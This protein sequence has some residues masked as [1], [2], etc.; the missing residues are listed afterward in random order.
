MKKRVISILLAMTMTMGLLVGCGSNKSS[1]STQ[2]TTGTTKDGAVIAKFSAVF[3]ATGTQAD[4][5]NKLGEFIK[6]E[7]TDGIEMEFYPSSQL[8]DKTA[9]MEGMISGT[10]EM[11]EFSATD[12]SN[13]DDM[14]SVFSLPYLWDSGLQAVNTLSDPE[15]MK[16]LEANAEQYG[17]MIIAWQN[18]GSR[19]IMNSKHTVKTPADLKGLTV[20]CMQ[21]PVLTGTI[22]A[23]GA[24]ATPLAWGEVYTAIQQ[25]T[26]DGCENSTPVLLANGL[27]E[28][29][30][31][32][33][34]TEQFIIPDPVVISKKWYDSLS[35]ENQKAIISAGE[36]Y[37]E[38][39]N[40]ELWPDAEATALE[41][42]KDAGVEVTEVDKKPFIEATQ[43]IV[44]DYLS[45]ATQEQ[46][47]LYE[48]LIE[49]KDKYAEQ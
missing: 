30:K 24:S 4:G 48:L 23:M 49:T 21:D 28:T 3:P 9:A 7:S 8:G 45:S 44:N 47:D 5:A 16:I 39:Y 19:S 13:Y 29:A 1:G 15:I 10:I 22:D 41:E 2:S 35:E 26:I 14:W 32:L 43:G 12:F 36:R 18:L 20:R 37:T 11:S 38:W 27:Q 31:Y 25:G 34:L 46:K 42:L 6:E 40:N 17:M 33:S